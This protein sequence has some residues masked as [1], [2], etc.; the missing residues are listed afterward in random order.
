MTTAGGVERF[1]RRPGAS[2]SRAHRAAAALDRYTQAPAS[3][4]AATW[5]AQALGVVAGADHRRHHRHAGVGGLA[6]GR[7]ELG[8]GVV[9]GAEP[10]HHVEEQHA[11]RSGRRPRRSSR[12]TRSDAVDHRVRPALGQPVVAE[13]DHRV[14]VRGRSS[15][16]AQAG[17]SGMFERDPAERGRRPAAS[18]RRTACRRR[19]ARAAQPPGRPAGTAP[20]QCSGAAQVPPAASHDRGGGRGQVRLARHRAGRTAPGSTAPRRAPGRPRRPRRPAAWR[21]PRSARWPR[22]RR[23][24]RAPAGSDRPA[25]S[26][27]RSRPPTPRQCETPTPAP[28]SS[29]IRCWA[30]VPEAA[31]MPDRAGA[32]DVGEPQPDAADD[33]RAA[34]GPHHQHAGPAGVLLERDLLLQRHVVAEHHGQQPGVHRVDRVGEGVRARRGDQRD[35]SPP[36]AP[37][38]S[39]TVAGARGAAEPGRRRAGRLGQ[40]RVDLGERRVEPSSWP[41]TATSSSLGEAAGT[42]KPMPAAR[43]RLSS[44]AIAT[45]ADVTPSRAATRRLTC[46]RVTESTYVPRRS[47][48]GPHAA[49]PGRTTCRARAAT[50][51]ASAAPGGVPDGEQPG[52]AGPVSPAQAAVDVRRELRGRPAVQRVVQQRPRHR[53]RTS[54]RAARR[55]SPPASVASRGSPTACAGDQRPAST[56]SPAGVSPG[57]RPTRSAAEVEVARRAPR[58][59]PPE[60][61][62]RW[63]GRLPPAAHPPATRPPACSPPTAPAAGPVGRTGVT[64]RFGQPD[65]APGCRRRAPARRRARS[66]SAR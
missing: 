38:P 51:S 42:S 62:A 63:P 52:S 57:P 32:H 34:V 10:E 56:S 48:D 28:S 9:G 45:S 4:S 23:A 8:G 31:T 64:S 53:R 49:P 40:R 15:P 54:G 37:P 66:R 58:A 27:D 65:R 59:A 60:R 20:V 13:V 50:P 25:T 16:S 6:H 5:R 3:L 36:T 26:A 18:P 33:R 19:T 24:G 17:S 12:S 11:G 22:R 2:R 43:S 14:A 39:G 35:A 44:V 29:D 41:S 30:P 7:R 47:C 61:S 46:I 1:M 55:G 21:P